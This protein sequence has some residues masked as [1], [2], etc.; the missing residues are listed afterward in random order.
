MVK[1]EFTTNLLASPSG[2]P[3]PRLCHGVDISI[4]KTNMIWR[5]MTHHRDGNFFFGRNVLR[6]EFDYTLP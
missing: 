3:S 6:E 2:A 4:Y 5:K 1:E